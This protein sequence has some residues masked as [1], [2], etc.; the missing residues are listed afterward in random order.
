MADKDERRATHADRETKIEEAKK[1]A[2]EKVINDEDEWD[3][4]D[5]EDD[6]GVPLVT[7]PKRRKSSVKEV[8]ATAE[9]NAAEPELTADLVTMHERMVQI[10][11][12]PGHLDD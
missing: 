5:V 9:R 8:F 6:G 2:E 3:V 7:P 4:A 1:L 12:L 10:G 11:L